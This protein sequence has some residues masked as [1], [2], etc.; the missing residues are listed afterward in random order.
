MGAGWS[1]D[2]PYLLF[3]TSSGTEQMFLFFGGSACRIDRNGIETGIDLLK[4][5]LQ[6]Y[7]L[8]DK[9]SIIT[10]IMVLFKNEKSK[11]RRT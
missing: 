7:D 8:L 3:N 1:S 2:I 5:N 9:G 11:N 4:S 6:G 10:T